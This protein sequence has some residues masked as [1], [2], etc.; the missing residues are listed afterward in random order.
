MLRH[1]GI[2]ASE[3]SIQGLLYNCSAPYQLDGVRCVEFGEGEKCAG[4]WRG[5]GVITPHRV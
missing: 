1:A 5:G 4:N 3:E 2:F